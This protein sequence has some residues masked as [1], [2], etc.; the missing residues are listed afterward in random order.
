MTTEMKMDDT[1]LDDPSPQRLV[2]R[3]AEGKPT[4]ILHKVPPAC[5]GCKRPFK[6]GDIAT[7]ANVL[8]G[9]K[10]EDGKGE[11]FSTEQKILCEKCVRNGKNIQSFEA[12]VYGGAKTSSVAKDRA[13]KNLK[14]LARAGKRSRK[15]LL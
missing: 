12:V 9:T 14:R 5:R 3:N 1:D 8:V 4:A 10:T 6:F 2:E 13:I 11:T 7:R 15:V